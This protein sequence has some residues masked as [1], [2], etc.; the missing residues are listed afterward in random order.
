MSEYIEFKIED[1]TSQATTLA[2]PANPGNRRKVSSIIKVESTKISR[3][4]DLIKQ[5]TNVVFTYLKDNNV[6]APTT[7]PTDTSQPPQ[8]P[9]STDKKLCSLSIKFFSQEQKTLKKDDVMNGNEHIYIM[10]QNDDDKGKFVSISDEQKYPLKYILITGKLISDFGKFRE[11][12]ENKK[13]SIEKVFYI[14]NNAPDT[15]KSTKIDE[16]VLTKEEFLNLYY[17]N[18]FS[19]DNTKFTELYNSLINDG[20]SPDPDPDPDPDP[21][22]GAGAG[23]GPN[24]GAGGGSKLVK[25][26]K[27][28]RVK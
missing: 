4:E 22:T 23:A 15:L 3:L 5:S 16:K 10:P 1:S 19:F 18:Y 24:L 8:A 9:V 20:S 13:L 17:I 21:G 26:K 6:S 12:G 25:K 28:N 14:L 7:A 2:T 11:T 27:Q